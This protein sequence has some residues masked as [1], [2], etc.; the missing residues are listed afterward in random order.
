MRNP[1]PNLPVPSV[2][3]CVLADCTDE[4]ICNLGIGCLIGCLIVVTLWPLTEGR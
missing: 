1:F 2:V 3:P 4:K